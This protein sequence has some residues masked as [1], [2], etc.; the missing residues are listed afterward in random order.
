MRWDYYFLAKDAQLASFWSQRFGQGK[1]DVL[2]ILA[3]GFDPRMCDGFSMLT[4]ARGEGRRDVI[5]I[6]F[7]EGPDSPSHALRP[8]VE[9]NRQ[10]LERLV[11][12][13]GGVKPALLKLV[14]ADGR[15]VE[16][17]N[18]ARLFSN[19]A[20]FIDYDDLVLDISALPRGIYFP[21]LA[22]LLYL[23]DEARRTNDGARLPNLHLLVAE[24]AA[25]DSQIR[26]EG[27]EETAELVHGFSGG[28]Q[29]QAHADVPCIWLPLLGEAQEPQFRVIQ[30]FVKPNEIL[31][32]L[33]SPA[34]NPRRADDLVIEYREIL[35]DSLRLDP[36]NFIYAHEQNP[37][38]VY[39][40]LSWVIAR[41]RRSLKPL[42]GARF[43]LSALSSKLMSIGPLLVAYELKPDNVVGLAHVASHGYQMPDS[44]T[45]EPANSTEMFG[46]WLVGDYFE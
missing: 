5:L 16:S 41:Y 42:G 4:E 44:K 45:N 28:A 32:V 1:R 27:I 11:Q 7:D 12:G 37:F 15:R 8:R 25:L 35:F 21:I 29:Q 19:V 20:E 3:L 23:L 34:R 13:L 40:Q 38:E 6:E 43:V 2:C 17:V 33:P 46:I 36:R 24:N 26:Q 30:D 39:R 14:G 10:K 9:Q 18:A 31:P 22:K